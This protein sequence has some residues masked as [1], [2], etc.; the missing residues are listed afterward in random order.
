MNDCRSKERTKKR[1]WFIDK[2]Q[3]VER[4]IEKDLKKKGRTHR[5]IDIKYHNRLQRWVGKEFRV[6]ESEKKRKGKKEIGT[7]SR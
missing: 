6:S 3:Y 7:L 5:C 1:M 4:E 2:L